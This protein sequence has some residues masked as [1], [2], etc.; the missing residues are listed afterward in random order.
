MPQSLSNGDIVKVQVYS[1]QSFQTAVNRLVWRCKNKVGLGITDQ[2]LADLMS[3]DIAALYKAWMSLQQR[4]DGLRVQI[5]R[6]IPWEYVTSTV[7]AGVGAI[8][9]SSAPPQAAVDLQ[10]RTGVTGKTN[11]GRVYLPFWSSTLVNSNGELTAAGVTKA[12]A[13]GTYLVGPITYNDGVGNSIDIELVIDSKGSPTS[14]P[15]IAAHVTP[16]NNTI[17]ITKFATQ[18]RRSAI[19]KADQ[20]GP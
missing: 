8:A 18:R 17:A 4:Y 12:Q 16:V 15:P 13:F 3:G 20:T 7:D 14:I 19:N 10:L 6:P 1:G 11:R 5:I 2:K 9:G